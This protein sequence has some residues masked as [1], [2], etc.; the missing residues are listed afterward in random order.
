MEK[1]ELWKR[2]GAATLAMIL[3]VSSV[4]SVNGSFVFAAEE[5]PLIV[6]EVTEAP[7]ET[8]PAAEKVQESSV[9]VVTVETEVQKESPETEIQTQAPQTEALTPGTEGTEATQTEALT[10]GTEG[11]EAL[12][13]EASAP[14]T[15]GTE[16]TQTEA[17]QTEAAVPETEGTE[18]P[19]TVMPIPGT[20]ETEAP[21][22]ETE[23]T[24]APQTEMS[25]L[26]ENGLTIEKI[27]VV[28]EAEPTANAASRAAE[29]GGSLILGQ[30]EGSRIVPFG[31]SITLSVTTA[32]DK[33]NM[34]G[35]K[36]GI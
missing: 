24:E 30:S 34:R 17:T 11:T 21:T 25:V 28:E 19:Q 6:E 10:P 26:A 33:G 22:P 9:E 1:K 16:A 18:A 13:T 12:Q 23:G 29:T 8:L 7:E 36:K 20:E 5:E 35:I 27:Q 14:E 32:S 3:T 31:E 15:E 2:L 4:G